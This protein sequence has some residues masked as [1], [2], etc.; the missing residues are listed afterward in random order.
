MMSS[1][2]VFPHSKFSIL[3]LTVINLSTGPLVHIILTLALKQCQ[4]TEVFIQ[5]TS[6]AKENMSVVN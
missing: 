2:E 6:L 1:E 3:H 5:F 4:N